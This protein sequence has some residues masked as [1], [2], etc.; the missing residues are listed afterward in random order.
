M[1]TQR[2]KRSLTAPVSR[3]EKINR[4]VIEAYIAKGRYLKSLFVVDLC[5]R[6]GRLPKTVLVRIVGKLGARFDRARIWGKKII[7]EGRKEGCKQCG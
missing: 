3:P 2:D 6:L 4:V 5:K 1:K 7:G